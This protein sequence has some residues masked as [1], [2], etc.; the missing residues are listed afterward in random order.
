M[1]TTGPIILDFPFYHMY[2]RYL[3]NN[4]YIYELLSTLTF[5]F[6]AKL[7]VMCF[8]TPQ[9]NFGVAY[10]HAR[11]TQVRPVAVRC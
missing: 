11:V 5:A 9:R 10:V 4:I 8:C 6:A 7:T 2:V 1:Y 3:E